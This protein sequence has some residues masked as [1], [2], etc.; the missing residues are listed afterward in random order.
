MQ[1]FAGGGGRRPA[2]AAAAVVVAAL[3]SVVISRL[4]A[5]DGATGP[6]PAVTVPAATPAAA[7]G[8]R[9]LI[10]RPRAAGVWPGPNGLSGVNGDPVQDGA[11]VAEFCRQRGR[12]CQVAHT[13]TDRSSYESMTRNA[14]WV[15]HAFADFPG[16]LVI[17]QALVPDKHPEALPDCAAGR[18]DA[19][20]RDFGAVMVRERRADTVIRLGWEFN[21]DMDWRATDAAT[22]IACY[23]RAATA[24]RATN[25]AVVLDWTINGHGTPAAVCDGLSTNCYPGDQFVDIIGIDN[26]DNFPVA[27]NKTE[28]DWIAAQPEGL[29]WL[30][31]FARAHGK[32]FSVGEWGVVPGANAGR[33]NADFVRWMHAWFAAHAPGLAYEAYFSDCEAGGVQSSLFTADPACAR[34]ASSAAAYRELYRQ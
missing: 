30:Y 2:I 14:G 34:N 22:W 27:E 26:Y 11:H 20:W 31:G 19:L 4:T 18:Y 23:R 10:D 8:A 6:A 12:A 25:P 9:A 33:G 29:D 3:A 15:F 28:F 32:L 5:A 16:A 13:Y 17:S 1:R 21:G 7:G 24:V